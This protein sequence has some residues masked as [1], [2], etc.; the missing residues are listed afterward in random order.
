MRG[1][2]FTITALVLLSVLMIVLSV[3]LNRQEIDTGVYLA[4]ITETT[5]ERLEIHYLPLVLRYT[6]YDVLRVLAQ[7][8]IVN[9]RNLIIP[10]DY[11]EAAMTG[12]YRTYLVT[13]KTLPAAYNEL[14]KAITDAGIANL[15][16]TTQSTSVQ[17]VG[18]FFARAT[19]TVN[20][21]LRSWDNTVVYNRTI[22]VSSDFLLAGLPDPLYSRRSVP[23]PI[24]D[25][26]R[27]FTI[28]KRQ[29]WNNAEFDRFWTEG[30]YVSDSRS[31]SIFNRLQN[32]LTPSVFG[33]MTIIP[34]S[35]TIQA[36]LTS[37]DMDYFS[38]SNQP[39]RY[40]F[41]GA[42]NRLRLN[43]TRA[44]SFNITG[45]FLENPTPLPTPPCPAPPSP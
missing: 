40:R 23:E 5:R 42:G 13:L 39:C 36:N 1:I 11:A 10:D 2:F 3:G 41:N 33:V 8:S 19:T 45:L 21:T 7:D 12:E 27:N 32:T 28:F 4:Q 43:W 6:A 29:G 15:S 37:L 22:T 14:A 26:Q 20:Y 34:K 35:D 9:N 18:T 16:I 17:Q 31:P 30:S 38:G 44:E 25:E 24:T